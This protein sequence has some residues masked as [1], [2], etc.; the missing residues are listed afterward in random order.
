MVVVV[1]V[2]AA[3]LVVVV[4]MLC[5]FSCR[6]DLFVFVVVA[7]VVVAVVVLLVVLVCWLFPRLDGSSSDPSPEPGSC[8]DNAA[9]AAAFGCS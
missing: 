2:V 3:V 9:A 8:D 7:V 1:V 6:N 5:G 4:L